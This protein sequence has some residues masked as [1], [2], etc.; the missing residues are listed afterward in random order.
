MKTKVYLAYCCFICLCL[1]LVFALCLPRGDRARIRIPMQ[2]TPHYR[3]CRTGAPIIGATGIMHP[4][5][6][7]SPA[8]C[9][10]VWIDSQE[11]RR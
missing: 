3:D 5:N 10:V 9:R 6:R 8:Y 7:V 11:V 4:N 1:W 2:Y